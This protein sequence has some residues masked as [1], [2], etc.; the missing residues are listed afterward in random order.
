MEAEY[1]LA[2]HP[3]ILHYRAHTRDTARLSMEHFPLGLIPGGHY[4]SA[5]ATYAPGDVF[6]M[7]TDGIPDTVNDN[8]EEFGLDRVE[9]ILISH[10]A[11]PLFQIWDAVVDAAR[12]HGPPEDDQTM[13]L[14]RVCESFAPNSN[15]K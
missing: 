8:D 5:H 7:L 10:A 4:T 9:Q 2:G 3:A 11:E 15:S 6:L 13:L 14:L 1:V 12:R